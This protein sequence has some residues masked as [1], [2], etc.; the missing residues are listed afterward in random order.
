MG[1]RVLGESELRAGF[2][3]H[4]LVAAAV[5]FVLV[6]TVFMA[7]ATV[8]ANDAA[9][10]D[11][12]TQSAG[13]RA[14][15]IG[16]AGFSNDVTTLNPLLFTMTVEWTTMWPCYSTILT[17][18]ANA[19]EIGDLARTWTMSGDGLNWTF[20]LYESAQFYDKNNPPPPVG[21]G[22]VHPLSAR[23]VIFTYNLIQ[24]STS[25]SLHNYLPEVGGVRLISSMSWGPTMYDLHIRLSSPFAPFL[26]SLHTIPILPMYIWQGRA[27]NWANFDT[28]IAP[29]IGSGP[30]YYNLDGLP[31]YSNVELV[32]SP[33]WLGTEERGWQLKCNKVVFYN[34][35]SSYSAEQDLRNGVI[36]IMEWCPADQY[37]IS[38]PT[39]PDVVRQSSNTGFEFEYNMNQMTDTMRAE[40]GGKYR[41]GYNNQLLIDPIVR[42][43]LTM[44]VDK[45]AFI[46]TVIDGL[47][48]PADSWVPYNHPY[49]YVYGS[50]RTDQ[51]VSFDPQA[52]RTML[53]NAGW[54]YDIS[55]AYVPEWDLETY[56]LCQYG[57]SNALQFRFYTIADSVDWDIG[58]RLIANWAS[59]A[60]IDLWS[61]YAI[62]TI[63][64]LNSA[65][66]IADFDLWLWNWVF[67][68]TSEVSADIMSV[69]TTAQIGAWSDCFYSNETYDVLFE[70]S[71]VTMEPKQ[72]RL[73]TDELQR[74]AYENHGSQPVAY[75]DDLFA[76]KSS[77]PDM[78]SKWGDWSSNWILEPSQAHPWL[79]TMIAPASNPPPKLFV[80]PVFDGY[81]N[82]TL[83]LTATATDN[84]ANLE[85]RWIFG[86]GSKSSWSTSP[87]VAHVYASP[88]D[89]VAT[90]VVVEA[91][92]LDHYMTSATTVVNVTQSTNQAPTIGSFLVNATR[93]CIGWSVDFTCSASDADGDTLELVFDFGD[94]T[95]WTT[96]V[97]SPATVVATHAYVAHG[98]FNAGVTVSDGIAPAVSAGPLTVKV[99]DTT[100]KFRLTL[101]WNLITLPLVDHNL[102]AR[103]LG[104][105]TGDVVVRW[106]SWTKTYE[107]YIVGGSPLPSDFA[108]EKHRGYWVYVTANRTITILGNYA[109]GLQTFSVQV[110]TGGG[111]ALIGFASLN[112]TR[113]ASNV[114]AMASGMAVT[115]VVR[116]DP[117]HRYY[118]SYIVG[119]PP[120]DFPLTP[121]EGYWI[122][123]T[124]SGTISYYP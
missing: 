85:Y 90:V 26:A 1:G 120:S 49:H 101:G 44:S 4:R 32:R 48:M 116:Y 37:L 12:R 6:A 8:P 55:G 31:G 82:Q 121:G 42:L 17:Y 53:R 74:M 68:L 91:D 45:Q 9:D 117:G 118:L 59:L 25:S 72:R 108:L 3:G 69:M 92:S 41:Q 94:G 61:G 39:I 106:N 76:M 2:S 47:G 38:I 15:R 103:T 81:V 78:W 65:W 34:E 96:S 28:G 11:A 109:V 19:T 16:W 5:F 97:A 122:W 60:G 115:T 18:D 86:D 88:G 89:Y 77:A 7:F 62:K 67:S 46:D 83:A 105:T 80:N 95:S 107:S 21:S 112:T 102:T 113:H 110:P 33:T 56:P 73:I 87:D 29:C 104:L 51:P 35:F 43:A 75:R 123:V 27:W 70:Q 71:L 13:N 22:P 14:L 111:W 99:F 52:A 30:L 58:A 66:A 23:D 40:L 100:F 98:A 36:D 54:T 20:R 64:E 24:N 10:N 50:D 57:G 63:G 124:G 84:S 93:T 119:L 114:P 79:Y